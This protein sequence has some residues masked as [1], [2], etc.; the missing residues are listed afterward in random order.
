[1][2]RG[3]KVDIVKMSILVKV[4]KRFKTIPSEIPTLL[5]LR[6]R[7]MNPTIPMESQKTMNSK[8]K[9][10]SKVRHLTFLHFK[11]DPETMLTKAVRCWCADRHLGHTD[12]ENHFCLWGH[13]MFHNSVKT[14]WW[15]RAI[16]GTKGVVK[17][18][19]S[20]I[21][22]SW[23]IIIHYRQKLTQNASKT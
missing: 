14:K 6:N 8:N 23:G 4:N 3:Y 16:Y 5:C 10:E 7:W 9:L 19:Y 22:F 18:G 13:R 21:E 17:T 12:S 20:H 11:P 2:L 15:R 1:M